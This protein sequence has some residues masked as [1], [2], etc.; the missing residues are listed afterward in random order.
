MAQV[1]EQARQK[2]GFAE[3][4]YIM[5]QLPE[6]KKLETE[7][8]THYSRLE[9]EMKAKNDEFQTKLKSYQNMPASTPGVIRADREKELADL[10]KSLEKF[11]QDAQTG[12]QKKQRELLEPLYKRV[13]DAIEQ[14]AKE[15]GYSFILNPRTPTAGILLVQDERYNISDLVLKKLGVVPAPRPTLKIN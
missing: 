6:F 5:S 10:Q 7:L 12:Y 9:N 13:G 11:K 2:V 3:A 15:N 4:E 1:A 14:V 8:S